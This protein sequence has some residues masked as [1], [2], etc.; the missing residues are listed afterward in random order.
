MS[1]S[2][3]ALLAIPL[4][5]AAGAVA[6]QSPAPQPPALQPAQQPAQQPA[7]APVPERGRAGGT[8]LNLQLD[9]SSRRR[10]MSGAVEEGNRSGKDLPS[11][12][13]GAR[14]LDHSQRS[15]PYPKSY[16]DVQAPY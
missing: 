14:P 10:I 3:P 6:A 4:L 7:A 5:A 8:T 2:L 13:E 1:P 9:D 15:S 16:N 11:L 12:G